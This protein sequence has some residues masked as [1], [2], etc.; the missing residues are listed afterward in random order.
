M[1]V[2]VL[3][4]GRQHKEIRITPD[5]LFTFDNVLHLRGDALDTGEHTIEVRRK[6]AGPLYIN[7]YL[8]NFTLED[9]ITKAGL[10]IKV[11]RRYYKLV[12][13]DQDIKATGSRGQALD[14][15]VEHFQRVPLKNGDQLTSGDLVEVELILHSK[16]DY[17]HL[18]FEDFKP[19]GLEA[20]R[21]QSGW[22][23]GAYMELRDEKVA[24]LMRRLPLGT[25]TLTYRLRAEI[26]GAFSA[27]PTTGNGVYAPELRAN[28]DEI[29]IKV[30]DR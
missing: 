21:L 26:P 3:V 28:S 13:D 23:K 5:N 17:E 14:Y 11:E 7:A 10:E 12:R 1:T 2:Q 8:T 18:L 6:G 20:V 25:Q 19:A 24:F 15:R 4:D 27:L 9:F 30:I 16:N 29:N 22:V